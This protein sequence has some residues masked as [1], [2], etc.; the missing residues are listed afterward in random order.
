MFYFIP[1]IL[2]EAAGADATKNIQNNSNIG[3]RYDRFDILLQ[4]KIHPNTKITLVN[5]IKKSRLVHGMFQ[6][7]PLY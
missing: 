7:I 5:K 6:L 1:K 4:E 3:I 2:P